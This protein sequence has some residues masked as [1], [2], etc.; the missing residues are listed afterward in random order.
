M[1]FPCHTR[2]VPFRRYRYMICRIS[3]LVHFITIHAI[4]YH[5]LDVL[6]ES[7]KPMDMQCWM[8]VARMLKVYVLG[9]VTH[10]HLLTGD[11]DGRSSWRHGGTASQGILGPNHAAT[12]KPVLKTYTLLAPAR[13]ANDTCPW[14]WFE[15]CGKIL[16]K[17]VAG[18]PLHSIFVVVDRFHML[19]QMRA[20]RCSNQFWITIVDRCWLWLVLILINIIG[21]NTNSHSHVTLITHNHWDIPD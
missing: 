21:T 5:P 20:D 3:A 6:E 13:A 14:L 7:S 18:E 16:E 19:V 2:R 8:I 15:D 10:S 17:E 12:C 11:F 9:P 4:V 1:D